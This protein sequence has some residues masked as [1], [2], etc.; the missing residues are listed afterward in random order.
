VRRPG[1]RTKKYFACERI[2]H[3]SAGCNFPHVHKPLRRGVRAGHKAVTARHRHAVRHI[4]AEISS[5]RRAAH[6]HLRRRGRS[7]GGGAFHDW[8]GRGLRGNCGALLCPAR[9]G[10]AARRGRA[11]GFRQAVTQPMKKILGAGGMKDAQFWVAMAEKLLAPLLFAA[12]TN[13]RTVGQVVRWLDEGAE[14]SEGEVTELLEESG[15]EDALRAWR[16]TLNREERQRA[17]VF[18]TAQATVEAFSDP[19]VI[20]ETAGADYT[21]TT[22]LDGGA[23]TLYLC[24]PEH[25]QERLAPLFSMLV[26]ELLAVVAEST[27]ATGKPLDP[28]LLLLL[29]EA[30]TIPLV[31]RTVERANEAL[32]AW[33]RWRADHL[34]ASLR[35]ARNCAKA[36]GELWFHDK[37]PCAHE[38]EYSAHPFLRPV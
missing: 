30:A 21:P 3:R 9:L 4:A 24:A 14:A 26:Q 15:S 22:L 29:D 13:G 25:E 10:C 27:T 23:N 8:G 7:R 1:L 16:A 31:T 33:Q 38:I 34:Q 11:K 20:E 19:Y 5:R 28:P 36:G 6:P 18:S 32:A 2:L 37:R 12:A 35:I 17:S